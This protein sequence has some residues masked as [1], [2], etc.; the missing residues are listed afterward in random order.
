[1]PYG[2]NGKILRVDLTTGAIRVEEPGEIIYRTYLGGGGLASYYLLRELKPGIDPLSADNILIFASSVISGAPI[3]GMVR[4]TVAAKSPLTGAY[5]EAEAGGFWG[6]EL[7]FSGFDAVI[8]TGKAAKPSYLWINDG[9]VEIRSAEK[10]WGMETG[11]AQEMIRE[12]IDEKRARV[13]LIGPAGE[14][15][16]RYACVVNELKHV[17]GRTGMGAVMGSKNL[18]AVAVRGTKKMEM[19]DPEKLREMSKNLTELI[20]QHGPNKVLRKLGTSNLIVPLNNQGILP[21]RNFRTG[22]FE[23]AEKI[24]GERMAETILKGEEGCYACA[25]RCKRAVEVPSGPYATSSNYGGPEYETLSSLG[26]LLCIDD[27]AAISKGNEMCNRY[28]LDTISTGAVIAFAMECY[29][30]GILVQTDTEGIDFTF[31]N[32]EAMLKG[33]EW[34]AFRKPGLGDLLADGVKAAAARIGRGAEKFALHIKGQELPMHDPRG[35]TGQGLSFAVSPTGADHVRAPHDTPFQAPGPMLGKIAPLGLLEP[36]D[37]REMGARKARNFT[38][39]H[40]IWSL[41]ESLGVCNFVAGPV[42]ALTLTKLVEVVQAVTGWETSLWE[43]MKVGERTVTMARVFNLREGFG[44]RDDT[45]P[46]R[47][48]EPLESGA[49][50]GKGLDRREFE[51]LLT[52]YYEAMGWDPADGVPTRG[53]LAELNLFWLDEFLKDKR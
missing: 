12:E 51:D 9:K 34:I 15:L 19:H 37:G 18:K 13:A 22:Y 33:I 32:P 5:G 46:D 39:L 50:Q 11:P 38:Y 27:L 23:G 35:K 6:P 36:V 7:K 45:L 53:K 30:N 28:T 10:I 47:L 2:Y 25:V 3:A 42:W 1:M 17:N 43:L 16:V 48:F 21:T 41:Y 14:N 24:S 8:V 26:S 44:R 49:L 4:F 29:E 20:G 52:L 31:G 40:F